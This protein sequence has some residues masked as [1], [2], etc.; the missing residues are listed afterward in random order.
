[1]VINSYLLKLRA[2]SKEQRVVK[3]ELMKDLDELC[4]MITAFS[5]K[6]KK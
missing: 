5:K 2:E 3:N 4:R 6:L 1:M